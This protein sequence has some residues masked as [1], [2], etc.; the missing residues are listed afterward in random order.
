MQ[1]T[2]SEVK[3]ILHEV[4]SRW[5]TQEEKI[6]DS[7]GITTETIQNETHRLKKNNSV[8]EAVI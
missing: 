7:E 3:N 1:T 4:S 6:S 5:N 2:M 8:R